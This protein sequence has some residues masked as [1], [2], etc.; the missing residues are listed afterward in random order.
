MA[1][2]DCPECGEKASDEADACPN[3]GHPISSDSSG[4]MSDTS[5]GCLGCLGLMVVIVVIVLAIDF[6]E[7]ED[8]SAP[9]EGEWSMAAIQCENAVEERLV[10][11]ATADHPWKGE[12]GVDYLGDGRYQVNSYVDAENRMGA[13]I[14]VYYSCTAE[15][16]DGRSW[17]IT[18]LEVAE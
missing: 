6:P 10:A 2:I 11:P 17:T 15:T 8:D 1:L 14:R 12:D 7:T 4:G 16:D 3:C 9:Y 18:E 13:E 5:Q